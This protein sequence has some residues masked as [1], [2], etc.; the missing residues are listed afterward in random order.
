MDSATASRARAMLLL[1]M[2]RSAGPEDNMPRNAVSRFGKAHGQPTSVT[3]PGIKPASLT[4]AFN[5]D[6]SDSANGPGAPG[7][8][9]GIRAP[10]AL[11]WPAASQSSGRPQVATTMALPALATRRASASAACGEAAY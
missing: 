7:G 6:A 2:A 9:G 11:R 3:A 8:G 5:F 1:R 4:N 10:R